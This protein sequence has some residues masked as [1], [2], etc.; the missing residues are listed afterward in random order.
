MWLISWSVVGN[1]NEMGRCCWMTYAELVVPESDW[2]NF[3]E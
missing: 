2:M 1:L 3:G